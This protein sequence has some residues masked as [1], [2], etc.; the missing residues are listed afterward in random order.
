[1]P[2][3]ISISLS[4][5]GSASIV[6]AA[7]MDAVERLQR[8]AALLQSGGGLGESSRDRSRNS[9]RLSRFSRVS[10][11]LSAVG[12]DSST[13]TNTSRPRS[14][15]AGAIGSAGATTRARSTSESGANVAGGGAPGRSTE[16]RRSYSES[17]AST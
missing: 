8:T 4:P 11:P 9:A 7:L 3:A 1:M 2:N 10:W 15:T 16:G 13:S 12:G 17:D 5:G 6:D 14:H